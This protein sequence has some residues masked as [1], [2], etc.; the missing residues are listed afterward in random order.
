ML[1]TVPPL[2]S[3]T[4]DQ[5]KG[6]LKLSI[7]AAEAAGSQHIIAN[8]PGLRMIGMARLCVMHDQMPTAWPWPR[9]S[10]MA[11]GASSTATR[12]AASLRRGCGSRGASSI[13]MGTAVCLLRVPMKRFSAIHLGKCAMLT[14][15]VS[16][17][18]IKAMAD[19][20]GFHVRSDRAPLR[21]SCSTV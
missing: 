6:A 4:W 11:R 15:N 16:S 8:D 9:S 13:P 17:R 2:P 10:A 1:S 3:H 18:L 20:E 21:C 12:S 19:V 5:G 7:E 14:T